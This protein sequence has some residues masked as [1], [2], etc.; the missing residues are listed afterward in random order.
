MGEAEIK[1]HSFLTLVVDRSAW[2]ESHPGHFS[3]LKVP[4][5]QLN[6]KLGEPQHQTDIIEKKKIFSPCQDS[7]ST[8]PSPQPGHRSSYTT[9][10][11]YCKLSKSVLTNN[12]MKQ[13]PWEA[14]SLSA[15]QEYTTPLYKLSMFCHN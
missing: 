3:P 1:F 11:Q 5:Y 2:S 8:S 14:R 12:C 9:P 10:A 13:G 15:I 7:N 6:T 4:Q